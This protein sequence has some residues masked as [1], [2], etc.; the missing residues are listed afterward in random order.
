MWQYPAW[1]GFPDRSSV[2]WRSGV[3]PCCLF[4]WV[5]RC[6]WAA[7]HREKQTG[8]PSQSIVKGTSSRNSIKQVFHLDCAKRFGT[9]PF[10][11]TTADSLKQCVDSCALTIGCTSV[12][13]H[14]R[15]KK[16]YL[17][18]RSDKPT[19]VAPGWASAHSSGCSGACD[20]GACCDNKGSTTVPVEEDPTP[21]SDPIVNP[22]PTSPPTEAN[23][24]A[25]DNKVV[26]IEG[27][28]YQIRC[29][30]QF[31]DGPYSN[32]QVTSFTECLKT[33]TT[34]PTCQGVDFWDPNGS[35]T[36]YLFTTT[37]EPQ[38]S[39]PGGNWAAFKV[40]DGPICYAI[41]IGGHFGFW[42]ATSGVKIE[43]RKIRGW[44]NFRFVPK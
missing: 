3:C 15:T 14:K 10:H 29:E 2:R 26:D 44:S 35:K 20:Q 9:T 7:L 23:C 19:T 31:K 5:S 28:Q 33:C 1:L 34:D 16:C 42:V 39:Y 6:G 24:P 32:S 4:H 13:F 37:G 11:K 21:T 18:K 41:S 12:D 17:G 40:W 38:N 30:K 36:C 43:N 22:P 25:D 27:Q 8:R